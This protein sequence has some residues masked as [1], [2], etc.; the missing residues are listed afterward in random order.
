[1]AS[2][3]Y[4]VGT[5]PGDPELVTRKAWRVVAES[6]VVAYPTTKQ[7]D[8]SETSFARTIVADAIAKT[9]IELPIGLPIGLAG[10]AREAVYDK[11]ARL[12]LGHVKAG[13]DVAVLC[14]G[15]PLFYGSGMHIVSAIAQQTAIEIIPAIPA[16]HAAAAM[17]QLPLVEGA[18]RMLTLPAVLSDAELRASLAGCGT[19]DAVAII[20][21]GRH[22]GRIK[23]LLTRLNLA[24]RASYI[25]YATLPTQQICPLAAMPEATP[26]FSLIL[27]T[28]G[29]AACQK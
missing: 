22:A 9:A 8:G 29:E 16:P 12:V 5:G 4:A 13:C 26:Y 14:E 15:D 10:P 17:A 18:G 7:A 25:A 20:K 28:G 21:L 23:N 2:V 6:P 3:V 27:I 19:G 11:A 1:M 24:Q